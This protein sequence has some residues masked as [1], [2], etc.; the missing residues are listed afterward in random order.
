MS[1]PR[2]RSRIGWA[3]RRCIG[4]RLWADRGRPGAGS[5]L[6]PRDSPTPWGGRA[7]RGRHTQETVMKSFSRLPRHIGIIPDGNRRWAHP[8]AAAS[9][10][11]PPQMPGLFD[12]LVDD[13]PGR[14]AGSGW[15]TLLDRASERHVPFEGGIRRQR[16]RH[17]VTYASLQDL[18]DRRRETGEHLVAGRFEHHRVA[19][20]Y[21]H[22]T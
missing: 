9:A 8:V 21:T 2:P 11:V 6:R 13:L 16:R 3:C 19:V 15:F 20:S 14:G 17:V 7:A 22:L 1:A 12:A 18:G 10:E 5:P 4:G